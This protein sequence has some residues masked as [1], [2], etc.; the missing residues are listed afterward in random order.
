MSLLHY[1]TI[2]DIKKLLKE[3]KI[4]ISLIIQETQ[5]LFNIY[6]K[7]LNA[8]LEIFPESSITQ[9]YNNENILYGIP[10]LI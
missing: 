5:R 1:A 8:A 7:S 9:S 4:T 10:G 3:K 2:A 6:N